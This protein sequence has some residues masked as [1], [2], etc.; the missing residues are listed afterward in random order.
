MFIQFEYN[1]TMNDFIPEIEPTPTFKT[2]QCTWL[3]QIVAF[4]LTYMPIILTLLVAYMVDYFYAIATLLISYLITGIVRSYMRNNSIPKQQQEY[5]Y[6]DKAIAAWFLYRT[7]CF[8]E[9]K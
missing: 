5:S 7:Y 9:Q 3:V 4:K 2:K 8:G 1:A 6:S